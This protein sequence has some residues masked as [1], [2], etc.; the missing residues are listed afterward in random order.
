MNTKLT[1]ARRFCDKLRFRLPPRTIMLMKNVGVTYMRVPFTP[2]WCL[3]C[4]WKARNRMLQ[5]IHIKCCRCKIFRSTVQRVEFTFAFYYNLFP[6]SCFRQHDKTNY[7][8]SYGGKSQA[9]V[10][11]KISFILSISAKRISKLCKGFRSD[12]SSTTVRHK[13]AQ[14]PLQFSQP[15]L[16][17]VLRRQCTT[18]F[19]HEKSF[20]C[21][22]AW[23]LKNCQE[24][25]FFHN[26]VNRTLIAFDNHIISGQTTVYKSSTVKKW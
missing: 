3:L 14:Y 23:S 5:L 6:A 18:S 7:S 20:L 17:C 12:N 16:N 2:I 15:V 25:R 8:S 10:P 1:Q 19:S 13:S 11:G 21:H 4:K 22:L 9:F 26:C 24:F